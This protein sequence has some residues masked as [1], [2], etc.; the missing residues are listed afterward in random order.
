MRTGYFVGIFEVL[1]VAT[2]DV[3]RQ[4][5]TLCDRLVVGVLSDADV[6]ALRGPSSI[7]SAE[8]RITLIGEVRT[9]SRAVTHSHVPV[10]DRVF[11]FEPECAA[12]AGPDAIALEPRTYSRSAFS[13]YQ[14]RA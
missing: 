6:E 3:L 13:P 9:V 14:P 11:Y 10:S 8:D 1:E 7:A 2:L 5:H 4:A 12:I